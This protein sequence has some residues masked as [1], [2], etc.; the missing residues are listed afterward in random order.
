MLR[1]TNRSDVGCAREHHKV[2]GLGNE[3]VRDRMW[4]VDGLSVVASTAQ[5]ELDQLQ[6]T[7]CDEQSQPI[8]AM[9]IADR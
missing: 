8:V 3:F 7:P 9:P 5:P 1:L 6:C 4:F 2:R